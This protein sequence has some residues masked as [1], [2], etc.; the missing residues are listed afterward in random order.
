V[1]LVKRTKV[2]NGV[3]KTSLTSASLARILRTSVGQTV[4]VTISCLIGAKTATAKR[5]IV[6][7]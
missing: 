5:S 3:L 2:T 4:S 7:A 6:L 1:Q